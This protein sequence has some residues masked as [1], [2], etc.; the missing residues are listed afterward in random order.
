MALSFTTPHATPLSILRA[1][2]V[3]VTAA[4]RE[5]KALPRL[6][7]SLANNPKQ[8]GL[9]PEACVG[10]D[11]SSAPQDRAIVLQTPLASRGARGGGGKGP[12]L[13]LDG[14]LRPDM[15]AKLMPF[16]K[17]GVLFSLKVGGRV[18]IGDEMGLGKTVQVPYHQ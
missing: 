9:G 1:S 4:E 12:E 5:V 2:S 16:Q 8:S 11:A 14:L 18:L 6:H 17:Q 10:A 15:L 7:A 3:A 13:S